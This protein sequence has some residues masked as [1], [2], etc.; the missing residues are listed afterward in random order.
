M[1]EEECTRRL[2]YDC[3]YFYCGLHLGLGWAFLGRYWY[4]TAFYVIPW[5]IFVPIAYRLTPTAP[6]R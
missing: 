5:L 4:L 2:I 6:P 3:S 1:K